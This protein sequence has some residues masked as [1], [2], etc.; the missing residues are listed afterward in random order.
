MK[1]LLNLEC[2]CR[3]KKQPQS[4]A[5]VGAGFFQTVPLARDSSGHRAT[6][7]FPSRSMIAVSAE[8]AASLYCFESIRALGQEVF[9]LRVREIAP[10]GLFG[11]DQRQADLVL[12]ASRNRSSARSDT[13]D[14]PLL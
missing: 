11:G 13:S 4:L 6:Y 8:S 3:F 12:A 9:Y 5:R 14:R 7:P 10:A 2:I 1:P